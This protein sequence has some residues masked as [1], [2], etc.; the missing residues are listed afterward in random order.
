M[1]D[2]SD[3]VTIATAVAVGALVAAIVFSFDV[4]IELIHDMPDILAQE[5]GLGGM[6]GAGAEVK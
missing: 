3:L 1:Q 4:S 5:F 2:R 6:A